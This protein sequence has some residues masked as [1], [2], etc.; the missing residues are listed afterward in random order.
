LE[1]SSK[2]Q[3]LNE[4]GKSKLFKPSPMVNKVSMFGKISKKMHVF[5]E[6][7]VKQMPFLGILWLCFQCIFSQTTK[8]KHLILEPYLYNAS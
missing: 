6:K 5:E 4:D 8:S 3:L 2:I 1:W 7:D